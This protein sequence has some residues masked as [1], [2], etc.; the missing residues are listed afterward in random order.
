LPASRVQRSSSPATYLVGVP[1]G[2]GGDEGDEGGDG[3]GTR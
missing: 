3:G 1:P 2:R